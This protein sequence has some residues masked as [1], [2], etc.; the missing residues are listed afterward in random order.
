MMEKSAK[1][2]EYCISKKLFLW[3][4]V[5]AFALGLT[6]CVIEPGQDPVTRNPI[7]FTPIVKG[8]DNA[9]G[10]DNVKG[11]D[12]DTRAAAG[13]PVESG[14]NIPD[15]SS[16]G[17]Y[18]YGES[19]STG[20]ITKYESLDNQR[21]AR[22]GTEFVYS[23]HALW[24]KE[25]NAKLCF[26][27]YYPWVDA[28]DPGQY[29]PEIGITMGGTNSPGM[30]ISY[31]VPEDPAEHIDLMWSR[32]PL[33]TGYDPV[34]MTFGHALARLQFVARKSNYLQ[35]VRITNIRIKSAVT[36]GILSVPMEG[37]PKWTL[38]NN[39]VSYTLTTSNGL[40]GAM[41]TNEY[42]PVIVEGGDMLVIPQAVRNMIIFVE[43]EQNGVPM[44]T[45][46]FELSL[47]PDW[48]MNRIISYE[49]TVT[50]DGIEFEA[51]KYDW[52]ETHYVNVVYDGPYYLKM[53]HSELDFCKEGGAPAITFETNIAAGETENGGYPHGIYIDFPADFPHASQGGWLS[54]T[55]VVGEGYADQP[56]AH[57]DGRLKRRVRVVAQENN[58]GAD[59]AD[60]YFTVRTRNLNYRVN[61]TQSKDSW[62]KLDY[63]PVYMIN[64]KTHVITAKSGYGWK[65]TGIEDNSPM[66]LFGGIPLLGRT[67]GRNISPG[68]QVKF[69]LSDY[70]DNDDTGA[71]VTF[72]NTDGIHADVTIPIHA[73]YPFANCVIATV[74]EIVEIPVR[75][76]YE[77]WA[78]ARLLPTGG[79]IYLPE[80][81]LS[82]DVVWTDVEGLIESVTVSG[83]GNRSKIMVK[84]VEEK[85]EGNAVIK[86][87]IN[88]VTRWSWHIWVTDLKR[89]LE[90]GAG[91]GKQWMLQNLGYINNPAINSINRT[92]RGLYYQFGRKDPFPGVLSSPVEGVME[93]ITTYPVALTRQSGQVS[94][95][96]SIRNPFIY[97]VGDN[98]DQPG[99]W[100][101]DNL[102]GNCM[103]NDATV[104]NGTKGKSVFDPC[105]SGW[106]VPDKTGDAINVAG[107]M[108]FES[109]LLVPQ[110]GILLFVGGARSPYMDIYDPVATE[111][112]SDYH[113]YYWMANSAWD[114]NHSAYSGGQAIYIDLASKVI[115]ADHVAA[116]ALGGNV[117]CIREVD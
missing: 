98:A 22:S 104:S 1:Y 26:F 38:L 20:D 78:D 117:R 89:T 8:A 84:S 30:K 15:G 113:G 77:I 39:R 5:P 68:D 4:L 85:G 106:R 6:G 103:W 9:K 21:V 82:V 12:K 3:L 80:Q 49:F 42:S 65:I 92:N 29:D 34:E 63:K 14:D 101:Y 27:G 74:G 96:E 24:P 72:S 2:N 107:T 57:H 109:S 53:T 90:D 71:F 54:V 23:P 46:D 16:F 11:A 59:R 19:L 48:E 83:S 64:D 88:G 66:G 79:G 94:I 50:G 100:T 115:S 40:N 7:V 55:S 112:I 61:I 114:S 43:A 47:T 108:F 86:L 81:N 45:F 102:S 33:V 95:A 73:E 13:H 17:V 93:T 70:I 87:D 37:T 51:K 111:W 91:T 110:H 75:K 60:T 76:V 58:T 32:V 10:A 105:P 18:A 28:D 44:G 97:Y 69:W 31:T 36:D 56:A 67:G 62:L 116:K 25:E 99:S 35:N 41:L 52:K